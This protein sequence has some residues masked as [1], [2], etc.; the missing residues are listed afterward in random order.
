MDNTGLE[1][2]S[3]DSIL[4]KISIPFASKSAAP[5]FDDAFSRFSSIVTD[6]NFTLDEFP[7]HQ[8][9]YCCLAKGVELPHS[10]LRGPWGEEEIRYL[11]WVMDAGGELNWTT[12]TTG[13]VRTHE[14]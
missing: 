9:Q 13:E 5:S 6:R 2:S 12:S 14:T 1:N 4:P 7:A 10:I 11:F 8:E 3:I